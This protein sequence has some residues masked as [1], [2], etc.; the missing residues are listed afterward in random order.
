MDGCIDVLFLIDIMLN[1]RTTYI[2]T[3]TGNE[4]SNLKK[5]ARQYI[6]SGKF[7]VDLLASIPFDTVSTIIQ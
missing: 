5:I 4:I 3:N 1:F 6:Y 2:D 7:F